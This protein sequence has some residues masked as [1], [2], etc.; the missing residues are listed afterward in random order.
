LRYNQIDTISF[1]DIYGKNFAVKD[2]REIPLM[3]TND[4]V[5]IFPGDRIDEIIS[6]EEF[7]GDNSEAEAYRLF[8]HNVEEIIESDY[9]LSKIDKLQVPVR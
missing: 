8:D 7:Y 1:T 9:S 4:T 5:K 6:R 2:M 3:V